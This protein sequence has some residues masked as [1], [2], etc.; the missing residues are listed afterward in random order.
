MAR[1]CLDGSWL[2]VYYP[3]KR[4]CMVHKHEEA[5]YLSSARVANILGTTKRTLHNWI[6][7][8]KIPVPDVNPENGYYRW[9]MPE[10]E[11]LRM[12]LRDAT[13]RRNI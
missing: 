10:V 7:T 11:S 9:T 3:V 8:G 4:L 5:D 13:Q 6:H 2:P 1:F 12:I